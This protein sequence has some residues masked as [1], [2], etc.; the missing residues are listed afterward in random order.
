MCIRDRSNIKTLLTAGNDTNQFSANSF[1][2]LANVAVSDGVTLDVSDLVDSIGQANTATGKST[3]AAGATVFSIN[4]GITI[5][6]G[7][8]ANFESLL[9]HEGNGLLSVTNH[10]LTVGSGTD[11]NISVANAISLA[12]TTTGTVTSA[13]DTTESVDSLKTLY[14]TGETNAYTITITSD[15]AD[16][17]LSTAAEFNAINNATSVAVNATSVTA[18]ASSNISDIKTLLT[19][20][21]DTNQF[22]AT[23]FGSLATVAVADSTLDVSDLNDSIAQANTAT[24]ATS[25][26][27]TISSGGT[28]NGGTAAEFTALL[29]YESGTQISISNQNLTVDSGTMSLANAVALSATTSGTV[30][31]E[32]TSSTTISAMLD[33]SSGLKDTGTKATQALTITVA[34]G[35]AEA[36]AANLTSLYGKT[37]VAVDAS[38]VTE[39]TGSVAEANIVYAAGASEITGL[40]N[41]TVVTTDGT[42]SDVTTLNT[43][44]GNTTGTVNAASVTSITG[45]LAKLLTAY[46]SNGITGLGNETI[47]VSDTGGGSSLAASDLNSLDSKTS[48]TITTAT[49]LVTLTVTVAALITAYGSEGLTLE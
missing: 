13:I 49:G 31:G 28:I 8:E 32:I 16:T 3:L 10:N 25:T 40:G 14:D 27:F 24:G 48:G 9:T 12:A 2:S 17:E 21:N 37:T 15:A 18:L 43:L 5:N 39:I 30:T 41:E 22:T 38:A 36:T 7:N 45:T 20:G 44:D 35:D 34:S 11:Q 4:T 47:S 46:G 33:G 1:A 23:S 19:A 26:S 29:G 6:G 42:L